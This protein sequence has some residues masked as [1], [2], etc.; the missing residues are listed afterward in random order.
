VET[1][2]FSKV[3]VSTYRNMVMVKVKVRFFVSMT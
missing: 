2:Y 1:A 3:M